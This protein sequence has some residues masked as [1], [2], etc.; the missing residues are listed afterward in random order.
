VDVLPVRY[1]HFDFVDNF[2]KRTKHYILRKSVH[3]VHGKINKENKHRTALLS[4]RA[5]NNSMT[6]EKIHLQRN[7]NCSAI[8]GLRTV[9]WGRGQGQRTAK[10]VGAVPS[11]SQHVFGE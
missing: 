7:L 5:K 1:G 11:N 10:M 2:I 6:A 4:R 9:C 3:Y 8:T